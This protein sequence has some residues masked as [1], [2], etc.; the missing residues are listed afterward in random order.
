MLAAVLIGVGGV[1]FATAF[2]FAATRLAGHRQLTSVRPAGLPANVSTSLADKMQLSP[3]PARLAPGF[4]L[5]DQ[6][7]HQ[8]SLA[9]ERGKVVVLTF[10]DPHCTDVCPIIS[11]E[12]ID[13]YRDLG[14]AASRVVFLAV[15]V[16]QYHRQVS[17][18]A[19]F[20]N[21]QQL[22][23]VPAWHFLTGSVPSLKA[24]WSDYQIEVDAPNPN[25]DV[26]HTSLVY[27]IDQSGKERYVVAPMDD[28]TKKGVA[29][30]PVV[31]LTTW[32]R[33]ISLVARDVLSGQ[34]G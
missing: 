30:L 26:I 12:F 8:V 7:G 4:T 33:G 5:T 28:H 27:F 21:E 6:A 32:A 10:M 2:A 11:R 14:S 31:Q 1:I 18:M 20:S 16:N 25:A 34:K 17:D 13:A 29:Y 9:S 3:V 23:T 19:A 15:N 22:G 24:I